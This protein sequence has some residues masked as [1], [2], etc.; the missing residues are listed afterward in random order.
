MAPTGKILPV[1]MD[2][3][4]NLRILTLYHGDR[5]KYRARRL[6]FCLR[7]C[8]RGGGCQFMTISNEVVELSVDRNNA[9]SSSWTRWRRGREMAV[10]C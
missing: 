10:A 6:L 3:T 1:E 2:L 4:D 7:G 5:M 8:Q 9:K